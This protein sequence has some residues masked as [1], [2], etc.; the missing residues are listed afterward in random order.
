MDRREF[1]TSGAIASTSVGTLTALSG[2]ETNPTITTNTASTANS[3]TTEFAH[4]VA[5]G[6]PLADRVILWTRVTDNPS[7]ASQSAVSVAWWASENRNG[8]NPVASG[9]VQAEATHDYCVKVD[10]AGLQPDTTY[11]YG[12]SSNGINSRVGQTRTLPTQE[13]EGVRLAV[14]SCAN[15]PQGYFNAYRQLADMDGLYAVLSLGDYLYE[16]GNTQY[17]DGEPLNRVP[18]PDKEI[19]TLEDYR[20]RHAQHKAESDLQDAHARHP[21]IVIWDDHESANNSWTGGAQNHDPDKGEGE[22]ST[23]KAAAIKSYYEWMPIRE[24]PSGLFRNFRF[25][26]LVDLIMLDTRLEGRNEP[27][28]RD[29]L[30]SAND[31]ERTLLGPVQEQRLF[32]H[33][34]AAHTDSVQWKVIGQQV[35]FAPWSNKT[36]VLNPDSWDGYRESRRRILEHVN[37]TS[38]DNMIILSGDVHSAWG[39]NVPGVDETKSAAIELVTPAVSSPP[40]ASASKGTQELVETASTTL[41]H[42]KYANGLD[43]GYLIVDLNAKRARAEWYFTGPRNQRSSAV[44]LGKAVESVSGSNQLTS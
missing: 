27:G 33:L 28:A 41:E 21:W 38:L 31:P 20:T 37:N 15:Y 29:D 10:A 11:Y 23:R 18:A 34:T 8:D 2:C 40:L 13:V 22:W 9:S 6:D 25:G 14:T 30:E 42:V 35:V 19:V 12:F 4:G 32:S 24:L 5:S 36:S 3:T 1:I 26:N 43:N 7:I 16:Y 44:K 39:M 17:G